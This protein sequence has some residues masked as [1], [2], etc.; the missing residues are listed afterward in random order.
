M[1]KPI[2]L[3]LM[4][5][6]CSFLP[7]QTDTTLNRLGRDLNKLL[8]GGRVYSLFEPIKDKSFE[9]KNVQE[10]T[11]VYR[12]IDHRDLQRELADLYADLG[13]YTQD[14]IVKTQVIHQ[15]LSFCHDS[16]RLNYGCYNAVSGL[17]KFEVKYFDPSVRKAIVD[18]LL[19]SNFDSDL[20]LI[21]GM[22]D[23]KELVPKF[24]SLVSNENPDFSK[25]PRMALA[26]MGDKASIQYFI[27]QLS[28][29]VLL[30]NLRLLEVLAYIRQP[31]TI[32]VFSDLLFSTKSLPDDPCTGAEAYASFGLYYLAQSLEAFPIKTQKDVRSWRDGDLQKARQWMMQHKSRYK[33]ARDVF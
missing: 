7:A 33:I 4:V 3:C 28:P 8:D 2:L 24:K 14:S 32:K 27:K 22:L 29:N 5:V 6:L 31:E 9:L 17:Q 12:Q 18:K 23:L 30:D 20:I 1:K 26:R 16:M 10:I 21:A 11:K 19:V 13:M 15:L 25:A